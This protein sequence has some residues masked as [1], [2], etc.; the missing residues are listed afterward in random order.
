MTATPQRLHQ[1]GLALIAK[2]AVE[3]ALERI[4]RAVDLA[5]EVAVLRNSFGVALAELGLEDAAANAFRIALVLAPANAAAWSNLANATK[6]HRDHARALALDPGSAAAHANLATFLH[7]TGEESRAARLWRCA[8]ALDPAE[9]AM[10]THFGAARLR[11]GE[12]ALAGRAF[13]HAVAADPG[14]ADAW[15]GRGQ[16]RLLEGDYAG[17]LADYEARRRPGRMARPRL[18]MPE[19]QG[20]DLRG[21]RILLW[22]EQGL[23]DA[24]QF[25]RFAPMLSRRGARVILA[26]PRQL[27]SFM[28]SLAGIE[29]VQALEAPLPEAGLSAPLMSLPFLLGLGGRTKDPV[30]PYL[31]APPSADLAADGR[32]RV[33]LLWAA[34][35]ANE[36][37]R[38]R[39]LSPARLRPLLARTDLRFVSLQFGE[40]A[41]EVEALGL[42]D[43]IETPRLGDFQE[44]AALAASL[45]LVVTVDTAMAHLAGSIGQE[46]WVLLSYVPDW[47]WGIAGEKTSWYPS[48]RLFRQKRPGDWDGA[49]ADLC[50]ALDR[51]F[52]LRPAEPC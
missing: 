43:R 9:A 26:V 37:G 31:S 6:R 3:E 42:A 29:R 7:A 51:R 23:G 34:S 32:P 22:A 41:G 48:L 4:G 1:E 8:L 49:I 27:V 20:E 15:I 18:A 24:I 44:T 11:E 33:G 21:K 35:Q 10:W 5:P 36:G 13:A 46:A 47:R 19:W 16:L 52:P 28:T 17:G 14:F 30:A 2:G 50:A 39:S 25:V 38:W 45:D 40:R 12:L